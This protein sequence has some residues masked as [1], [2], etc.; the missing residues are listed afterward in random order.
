MS[1]KFVLTGG[2]CAGKTTTL[3]GLMTRGFQIVP[4]MARA[5][6]EHQQSTGGH[7]LPW[8]NFELFQ[9]EIMLRQLDRERA[10]APGKTAFVDRGLP[11]QLAYFRLY[12]MPMVADIE[13]AARRSRY[14]GV[15][16][17]D[18]LPSY[19]RDSTR[20]ET[21]EDAARVHRFIEES[22]AG[23]GYD[24]VRVPAMTVEERI[25]FIL[26]KV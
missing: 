10:L 3:D 16:L 21:P 2:P 26:S 14:D 15:F 9:R 23:L 13:D 20:T 7:I 5:V 12:D 22:Y 1:R 11:D 24:V 17:L 25:E 8:K 6:I 4:E 18:M 19:E